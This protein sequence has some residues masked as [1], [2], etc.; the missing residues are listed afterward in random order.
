MP[1]RRLPPERYGCL[2][3]NCALCRCVLP[4]TSLPGNSNSGATY[5]EPLRPD[6]FLTTALFQPPRESKCALSRQNSFSWRGA[7]AHV[8][9][10]PKME[11]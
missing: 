3:A 8:R 2:A 6:C 9:L 4:P 7:S 10:T 11:M 1:A 5:D